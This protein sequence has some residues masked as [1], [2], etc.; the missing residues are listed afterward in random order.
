MERDRHCY[1]V[2]AY[3]NLIVVINHHPIQ[4]DKYNVQDMKV[5]P[6]LL[7]PLGPS[8]LSLTSNLLCI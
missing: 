4:I 2:V 6:S 1:V 5:F 8:P 3:V 7:P